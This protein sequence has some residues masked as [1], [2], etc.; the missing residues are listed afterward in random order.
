MLN[1]RRTLRWMLLPYLMGTVILIVIPAIVTLIL[2]FTQ[3]DLL[4]PPSWY[5]F[6]NFR[7]LAQFDDILPRAMLNSLL[8][9]LLAVPLRILGALALAL[10]L[11]HRRRGVGLYRT[12]VY[13]PTLI[14]DVAYALIWLWVFNPIYGPLNQVLE[15]IGIEGPGWL[16]D[17][18]FALPAI[19]LMSVFQIGEGFVVLLAGLHN[20]PRDYYDVAAVDGGTGWQ[21]FRYITFPLLRPWL[22]LLTLRDVLLTTQNT[23]TPAYIMTGGD[24]YYATMFLPL[25]IY[26]E[27]FEDFR[28]GS[29]ATMTVLMICGVSVIL[30]TVFV[31]LKG[32]RNQNAYD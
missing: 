27:T 11:E 31:V 29:G 15:A 19:V 3:Y 17:A 1:Y 21:K 30:I 2:A 32:W 16:T 7:D 22:I 26:K 23:F 14:P 18:R 25:H 8:F 13:L 24:P 6:N 9:V 4:S 12:A 28:Y 5:G 20:I 10:F